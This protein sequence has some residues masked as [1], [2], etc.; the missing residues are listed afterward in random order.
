MLRTMRLLAVPMVLLLGAACSGG[1]SAHNQ[2]D[3]SF[4]TGMIPHHAQAIVMSGYADERAATPQVKKLATEIVATQ[5]PE[6]EK[7]EGL[8]EDWDV[9]VPARETAA[10]GGHSGV[11]SDRQLQALEA[12]EGDA[13]DRLFAEQMIR[14]HQGA[15]TAARDELAEGESEKAKELAQA[16]VDAQNK[17][18][19]ELERIL[20]GA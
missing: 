9:A 7:M 13:F 19:T 6:I 12:S 2:A 3:I 1:D 11:L 17:Q 8:L 5:N 4:V 15:V 10:S 16:I 18:I 20:T 14:H